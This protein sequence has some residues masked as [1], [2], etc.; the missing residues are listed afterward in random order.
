LQNMG[1][2]THSSL[3]GATDTVAEKRIPLRLYGGTIYASA[4][5][6]SPTSA[7]ELIQHSRAISSLGLDAQVQQVVIVCCQ[8]TANGFQLHAQPTASAEPAKRISLAREGFQMDCLTEI[9]NLSA[10]Q[11][12]AKR[13]VVIRIGE[14]HSCSGKTYITCLGCTG[15]CLLPFNLSSSLL[16][17]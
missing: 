10:S 9:D 7:E 5:S 16:R 11:A 13:A 6:H 15:V 17:N 14:S 12:V 4:R 2:R 1:C 3:D 8:L